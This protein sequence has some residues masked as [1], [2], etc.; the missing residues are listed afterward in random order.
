MLV[1]VL[2]SILGLLLI[3]ESLTNDPA[4]I[5][6]PDRSEKDNE[7]NEKEEKIDLDA[8]DYLYENEEI[9]KLQH[10]LVHSTFVRQVTNYHLPYLLGYSADGH[11]AAFIRYI[12]KSSAGYLVEIYDTNSGE[13]VFSILIPH[14]DNMLESK[15][16][17]WA[18][19][20]L[21]TGFKIDILPNKLL[22]HDGMAYQTKQ[23]EW[24]L[25]E[26]TDDNQLYIRVTAS[27][28]KGKWLYLYKESE[29]ENL[30][31]LFTFP[32]KPEWLTFISYS[33]TQQN[34]DF[35]PLFIHLDQLTVKNSVAG[36]KEEADNWLYGDFTFLFNQE[37]TYTRK[38]YIA[39]SGKKDDSEIPIYEELLEQWIYLGPLGNMKWYGNP[40][41]I[42]NE[43]G[44]PIHSEKGSFYYRI[45]IIHDE[46]HQS[47]RYFM[48]DQYDKNTNQMIQTIEFKW[49]DQLNEMVPI[50]PIQIDG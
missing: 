26:D 20:A 14:T 27:E 17:D 4:L 5:T 28:M 36:K 3:K 42:F 19:K 32:G 38:G 9:P 18:Q 7:W 49:D 21:D 15:A 22:W 25:R 6:D 11:Y 30:I 44:K 48:I 50:Q 41:G 34:E 16:I 12:E 37:K 10:L 23:Q 40:K 45:N 39:V 35:R 24:I 1:L 2:I 8:F 46:Q 43:K 31:Q 13:K 33:E 29:G 47:M